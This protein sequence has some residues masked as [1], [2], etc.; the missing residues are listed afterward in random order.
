VVVYPVAK[1]LVALGSD[2]RAPQISAGRREGIFAIST[3]AFSMTVAE[4]IAMS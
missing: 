2:R 3:I 4:W 1:R